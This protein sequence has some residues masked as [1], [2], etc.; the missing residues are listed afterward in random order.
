[1]KE[2]NKGKTRRT[3]FKKTCFF[4]YRLAEDEN[5]AFP[6]DFHFSGNEEES[7]LA[8]DL[9]RP[10][11]ISLMGLVC[12]REINTPRANVEYTTVQHNC[13]RQAAET[14][15]NVYYWDSARRGPSITSQQP[16]PK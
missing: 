14:V 12:F 11:S 15:I 8:I 6:C 2:K 10:M 13:G 9:A 3:N 1:M 7:K 5:V 4:S 16:Y